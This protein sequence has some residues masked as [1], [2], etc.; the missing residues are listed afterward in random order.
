[1]FAGA[2]GER[3]GAEDPVPP[4]LLEGHVPG[5]QPAVDGDGLVLRVQQLF[6][7]HAGGLELLDE[8][9]ELDACVLHAL[10]VIEQFLPRRRQVLV[11]ADHGDQGAE[12]HVPHDDQIAADG[13]EE[14]RRQLGDEIIEELDE[15]LQFGDLDA[16]DENRAEP[17]GEVGQ[18]EICRAVGVHVRSSGDHLAQPLGEFSHNLYPSLGLDVDEL[19]DPRDEVHLDRIER[20]RGDA[21]QRVLDEDEGQQDHQL[22]ALEGGQRKG[23]AEEAA[24]G[25]GLGYHHGHD[26]AL[27]DAPEVGQREAHDLLDQLVAQA[28]QDAL[29]HGAAVN[30]DPQ[31]EAAVD[32]DDGDEDAAQEQQKLDLLELDPQHRYGEFIRRRVDRLVDDDFRKVVRIIERGKGD[33]RDDQQNDLFRPAVVEGVSEDALVH[34]RSPSPDFPGVFNLL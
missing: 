22:A 2:D 33:Q 29:G 16:D 12:R 30:V 3:R 7:D 26:L 11:G 34:F 25:L 24:E 9:Y 13:I 27:R 21:D 17:F 19:L 31:L 23:L 28:A 4:L 1:M 15:E 14:E 18:L 10:V 6:L 32:E 20:N 5:L 8:L